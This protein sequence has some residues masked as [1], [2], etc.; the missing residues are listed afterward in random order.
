MELRD[1][2]RHLLLFS[3][4]F[5]EGLL[6]SLKTPEDWVFQI[7][8][9]V[10]HAMWIAGHLALVD[11]SFLCRFRPERGHKPEGWDGLFGFGSQPQPSV[12]AYPPADEVLAYLRER[13]TAL[14]AVLDELTEEELRA[15]APAAGQR[16][17]IAGAPSLG[18]AFLFI[19]YHEGLHSGQLTVAHRALGH[20][21]MI[22]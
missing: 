4:R 16:S 14:L 15:A 12:A 2:A 1:H 9:K 13:R 22:G 8:P 7:H 6:A 5:T 10:N 20:A 11:N 3:R 19:A 17:P 18:H 21:P